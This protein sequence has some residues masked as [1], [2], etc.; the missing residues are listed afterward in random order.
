MK[1]ILLLI[2]TLALMFLSVPSKVSIVRADPS[3]YQDMTK[4]EAENNSTANKINN[5][6]ASNGQL[7]DLNDSLSASFTVNIKDNTT[8]D[9][10]IGYFSDSTEPKVSVTVDGGSPLSV[11][12][13]YKNGWGD[14]SSNFVSEELVENF[15]LTSGE[16]TIVV[17][18]D[19][20]GA[21]KYV[22]LDYIYLNASRFQADGS[23]IQAEDCY[24]IGHE[25][26][27]PV[28][29]CIDGATLSVDAELDS[30]PTWKI[31]VPET[32][33]Y[34]F[35]MACYTNTTP[36]YRFNFKQATTNSVDFEITKAEGDWNRNTYSSKSSFNVNLTA[37]ELELSYQYLAQGF[38]DF[39][40]FKIFKK[41]P[42][43]GEKILAEDY[44]FGDVNLMKSPET[45]PFLSGYAA[46]LAKG[47]IQF[48]INVASAGTY[49]LYLN[50]YT[51]TTGAFLNI[52]INGNKSQLV[53]PAN[54]ATGWIDSQTSKNLMCFEVNL[55]GGN[56]TIIITKGEDTLD[57]NYIDVDYFAIA[58]TYVGVSVINL[59]VENVTTFDLGAELDFTSTYEISVSDETVITVS[60]G[61][62]TAHKSGTAII[63]I[64]YQIDGVG[65]TKKVQVYVSKAV[66][67][68]PEQLKGFDTT[69]EYN[70]EVQEVDVQMPDGWTCLQSG[71]SSMV[72]TYVITLTFTHPDY[73][74][75][76]KEAEAI[77]TITRGDYQGTDLYADDLSVPYDGNPHNL[78]ASAPDGW[79]ITYDQTDLRQPGTY[80]IQVTFTHPGYNTVVKTGTLTIYVSQDSAEAKKT[81]GIIIA[82]S[83][84]GGGAAIGV[85]AFFIIKKIKESKE[86]IK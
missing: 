55:S 45:Y 53:V 62:V 43:L 9:L 23:R 69:K 26:I 46:E 72:G 63:T 84:I 4:L 24:K 42:A 61:I 14:N 60:G 35:Q 77:L 76:V 39:D 44:A 85:A 15:A 32:G 8:Y 78:M 68:H 71:A 64:S 12:L 47:K 27:D 66:F 59:D 33:E 19:N 57:F 73:M 54:Y 40:W 21:G 65:F 58:K 7:V 74:D 67:P 18:S 17:A 1:K 10:L 86:V 79:T 25:V 16:H 36:T 51:A 22:N 49:D 37:G 52:D 28:G 31:N 80:V 6:H 41:S 70:G 75:V 38:A 29:T 48:D 3:C 81:T 2:P 82:V 13:H 83:I 11:S 5:P 30:R 56:N 20:S 34:T 50:G